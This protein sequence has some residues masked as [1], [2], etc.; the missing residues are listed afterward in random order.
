MRGYL[1]VDVLG[2]TLSGLLDSGAGRTVVN[3]AG[4]KAL[5]ACGLRLASSRF[6]HVRVANKGNV[7]VAGEVAVPFVVGG[8]CRLIT[9]LYVPLLSYS[10]VLGVDF[11]RR[12]H[13]RPDFITAECEMPLDALE[14]PD[15]EDSSILEESD[16]KEDK[17]SILTMEQE[18]ELKGLMEFYQPYIDP[19]HLG[20]VKGVEHNINTGEAP[21][22]KFTYYN[23]NPK[24]MA[25]VHQELDRRLAEDIC[26]PSDSPYQSPLL[27]L[28]KKDGGFRWVVDFRRLNAQILTPDSSY[29]LPRINPIL[30]SLQGATIL[31]T[32]D[33]SDAYLQIKLSPESRN[34]T[35]FYV[36]GRGLFQYKR[37]PA[38]LKDA[39]S[40][41]QK[42]LE[43]VLE[44]VQR[45]DPYFTIYMDDILVWS[46][47]GDWTHHLQLLLKIFCQVCCCWYHRQSEEELF[48]SPP[49]QISWSH[50]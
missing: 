28:P 50:C 16:D 29:P 14:F 10:L 3:T 41:W 32:I 5:R 34:K 46:P 18:K 8:K 40:R 7:E 15:P 38:G 12:F 21:P 23:L 43:K 44:E 13:L 47:N 31:S 39:A 4:W 20:C 33:V 25:D 48:W 19:G 49:C 22:F 27:I 11:W 6:S 35:A 37:M 1:K 42:T 17:E 24:V 26:E 30:S 36:P 2:I 9:V 45:E